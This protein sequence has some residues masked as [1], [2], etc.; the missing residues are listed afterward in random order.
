MDGE[1]GRLVQDWH[2]IGGLVMDRLIG[3][4]LALDFRIGDRLV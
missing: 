1:I 3:K 4:G 2:C